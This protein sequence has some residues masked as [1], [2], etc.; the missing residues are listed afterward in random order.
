MSDINESIEKGIYLE[1]SRKLVHAC[2]VRD[3]L[4]CGV[5]RCGTTFLV[6]VMAYVADASFGD[7]PREDSDGTWTK[8]QECETGKSY[9]KCQKRWAR[10]KRT[11]KRTLAMIRAAT[12]P[13][14]AT[15][16]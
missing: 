2:K 9:G 10:W 1:Y 8:C 11:M 3:D 4:G 12:E 7:P 13:S 5:T 14:T 16:E 15:S 6:G